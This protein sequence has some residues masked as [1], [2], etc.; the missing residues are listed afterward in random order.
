MVFVGNINQPVDTLLKTSHLF[1]PFPEP[2]I[3]AA[4][5]DRLHAYIPGWEIPK[6]RPEFFTNQYGLIVDYLAE[7]MREMRKRTFALKDR[8]RWAA[9][10]GCAVQIALLVKDNSPSRD[11]AIIRA[12]LEA[13]EDF[14]LPLGGDGDDQRQSNGKEQP[15]GSDA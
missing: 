13:V 11:R 1:A 12:A 6:M 5:F 3:D 14:L 4:F 2:M 7:W 15:N 10:R 8:T 9:A